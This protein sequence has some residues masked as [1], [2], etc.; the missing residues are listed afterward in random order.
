MTRIS[1]FG[2]NLKR[3]NLV[4]WCESVPEEALLKQPGHILIAV[5][6]VIL[7]QTSRPKDMEELRRRV[8]SRCGF[9]THLKR[10]IARVTELNEQYNGNPTITLDVTD[11]R[12]QL[13]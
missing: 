8:S 9:R 7:F 3:S 10:L 2:L 13:R 12:D 4:L 6:L 11:L 1:L 5:V